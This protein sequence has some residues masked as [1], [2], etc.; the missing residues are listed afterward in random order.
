[1]FQPVD[2]AVSFPALEE[3]VLAFWKEGRVYEQS[4]AQREGAPPFV[5]YEGPPTA[6]GMP[7]PGH[8]LTR[9]IKDVFPRYRTMRGFRCERKAGWDT[10]GLPVEVEVC[11]ELGI[12][13][14]DEIEAYGI[15][16]FI[17]KCQA[18]V[19]RYMQ[20]WRRLTERLGF[21]VN[22][23]E[24][25]VT[26]HQSYIESVWW[27]LKTLFDRGLL[28]QGHKIVWWWAQ[29][30]TALSAGEVG[31]GYREVADPSVY[32]RFRLLDENACE[33][34]DE[35]LVVWTTTPWTLP[36]NQ[37]AAV[38]PELE[39]A[40][41]GTELDGKPHRL[42]VAAK[43]VET[44]RQK[45]KQDLLEVDE[46]RKG[47]DLIGHRYRPPFDCYYSDQAHAR[48]KRRDGLEDAL[49]WRIVGA[50]FVTTDSGTGI[51]HQAPAFGEVDYDVLVAERDRFIEDDGPT[52]INCVAPDG[53]FTDEAP[54]F[55]RGRWVK[56]CDK[57]I[58]RDLK[59]RGLLFHQE[60]YLHDYPFCWRAE[61]DPLIQYPRESWFIKT[62]AYK[63]AMVANNQAVNWLPEHIKDG[64]MGKFLESNVDWALSRERYWGTPLPI[65]QCDSTG[66]QEAIG[67]YDELLAKPGVAGTDV[68]DR[69]KAK[70]PDLP[71]DLRVHKPYI[72]AVTYD[73]PFAEGARMKRVTEVIDC[74]YDSGAMPFA[75]W[76]YRGETA[77][78]SPSSRSGEGAA[79]E[80]PSAKA[81]AL[82]ATNPLPSPPP[83]GEGVRRDPAAQFF[84][85]FPADFISEALDQT[86]GWFYSQLAISTMLFGEQ[87]ASGDRREKDGAASAR[88]SPLYPHPFRNCIVLGLMLGEDGQKMSKSKRNYREPREIFDKYG[89]DALRWYLLA[90][91]PPWTAI[92][93]SEQ[94]IKDS[95]P[96]FLLRLWN[97]YSF[98]VIYANIDGWSP[99]GAAAPGPPPRQG[100]GLGEGAAPGKTLTK[101]IASRV[102]TPSPDPSPC[103]GR[104]ERV[105]AERSELDRW[106][107]SELHR[108][109]ASVIERMDAYDNFTACAAITEFVDA[110]SNWWV[111]R[112]RDRFWA[113]QTDSQEK[114]DAYATLYECLTTT[115]KIIAP[116]T[117]FLADAMWRNLS[118]IVKGAP[119]S[120]HLCDFPEPDAAAI[121][122]KLSERMALVRLISSLGR[123]AREGAELKVRQP[124]ARVEVILADNTHQAWLEEH[125][126]VI[127][128]ELNVKA[129]EFSDT[130]EK[131]VDHEVLPNFK[132]LGKRLGKL[133]PKVKQALSQQS[134]S[135]LLANLRDNGLID[136]EIEGQA[137]Q[138][139]P[140]EVE[141]RI[142]AK[143]GWASAND[144][145]VVAVLSTELT[146]ELVA[147]GLARDVVR[148]IQDTR[149][150][151]GCEFTDRIEIGF[152]SDSDQLRSAV[153][154]HK[155]YIAGETLADSISLGPLIDV[156]SIEVRIG[157]GSAKLFLRVV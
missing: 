92:R 6:N 81:S 109:A 8:C 38:H 58:I 62:T 88:P 56:D 9:T 79:P 74:W 117:P 39:Y 68:W 82:R 30:G 104:G 54:E 49:A 140:E 99:S 153:E 18:S 100:E 73:S 129:V 69:A 103:G 113:K 107:I 37:F 12:H 131:Y 4:L 118:G 75:Q 139:T 63:D 150:E 87:E 35:S 51:V 135:E 17:Q 32:V 14:K 121:D 120:V 130:P 102:T 21:W 48:G 76:G 42:I 43:L 34:S 156:Q 96:E 70:N 41:L 33:E 15:E 149:K 137:V 19:W 124:L 46:R 45:T 147:E 108:T 24:A 25:Y 60:Q 80:Q 2:G 115:C 28:Y 142:Q 55:V 122:Q 145:G 155:K 95:I 31:Q 59:A 127:A 26:Y 106:I 52:L 89:A 111:R 143:P 157:D 40:A 128:D 101:A 78:L 47:E 10:H 44:L 151:R 86:R 112:S 5:F 22:L 84:S 29:G 146:P 83:A 93:Y 138:L 3:Q 125:A 27:S 154:S 148:A 85:Q 57:D 116:F 77:A 152:E 136:L 105:L 11:K 20:E 91:Q 134:G 132:L 16:P 141:V 23:D 7:H 53:K 64:R 50:D 36:S 144:K 94:A 66:K 123:R 1:M 98:L 61:E 90:N 13:S 110:L 72:D 65:W 133:M 119:E 97:C 67:G 71:D 126:G 114:L